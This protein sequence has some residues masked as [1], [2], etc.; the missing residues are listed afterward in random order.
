V[1]RRR[2]YLEFPCRA[3]ASRI[4]QSHYHDHNTTT[5][6]YNYITPGKRL[7]LPGHRLQSAGTLDQTATP[8]AP[9]R[10]DNNHKALCI[11]RALRRL[12]QRDYLLDKIVV[13]CTRAPTACTGGRS[14]PHRLLSIAGAVN[15]D[16][17]T[18]PAVNEDLHPPSTRVAQDSHSLL[19]SRSIE[20]APRQ[21]QRATGSITY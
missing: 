17:Q 7:L 8:G 20:N 14:T 9:D 1:C 3:S 2:K 4:T 18:S 12:F 16:H 19:H 11:S 5:T 10:N 13:L 21:H 15:Q 6:T